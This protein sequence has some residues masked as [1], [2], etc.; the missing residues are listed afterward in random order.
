VIRGLGKDKLFPRF[1]PTYQIEGYLPISM[2]AFLRNL[3]KRVFGGQIGKESAT[4]SSKHFK[5]IEIET[6]VPGDGVTFAEKGD[7]V[8]VHYT[9]MLVDGKQFDSSRDR[10]QPF[11]TKIGVGQVIAG[12]DEGFT[13]LSVGQR[14]KLT[15][16]PELA[17][18][19][20]GAG[21]VIPPDATLVFDVE[22]LDIKPANSL[23]K[24]EKPPLL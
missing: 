2:S 1:V 16:C 17:Y 23:K 22:L 6:L 21:G 18:G 4:L 8:V 14:A 7:I 20:R 15:I 3:F 5:G 12:W 10:G 11:Q 13:K 19:S 24:R 9:G